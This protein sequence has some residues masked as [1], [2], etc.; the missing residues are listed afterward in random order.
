MSPAAHARK[1]SSSVNAEF[2]N[3]QQTKLAG[4][5]IR[6]SYH[7][8]LPVAWGSRTDV[9]S[10]YTFLLPRN[11]SAFDKFTDT[12]K[13]PCAEHEPVLVGCDL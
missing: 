7:A 5:R 12:Y 9:P 1:A 13:G 6:L 11:V 3:V 10:S 8:S 4:G 2:T